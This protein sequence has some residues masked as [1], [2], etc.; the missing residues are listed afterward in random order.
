MFYDTK[1]VMSWLKI[2]FAILS[3]TKSRNRD[4][5][6]Y[7][8]IVHSYSAAIGAIYQR[9]AWVLQHYLPVLFQIE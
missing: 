2:C 5:S 8:W 4:V 6:S 1:K 3:H 7:M 9:M